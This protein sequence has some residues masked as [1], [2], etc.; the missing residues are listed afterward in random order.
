MFGKVSLSGCLYPSGSVGSGKL[1]KYPTN[2]VTVFR[3]ITLTGRH[4][5]ARAELE[6]WRGSSD[7][8]W[9]AGYASTVCTLS[10][11]GRSQRK[12]SQSFGLALPHACFLI[13]PEPSEAHNMQKSKYVQSS[14][15]CPSLKPKTPPEPAGRTCPGHPAAQGRVHRSSTPHGPRPA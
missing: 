13:S 12:L 6:I 2:G 11:R 9:G 14:M 3:G 5:R 10:T 8:I 15:Y 7:E 4:Y 1:G